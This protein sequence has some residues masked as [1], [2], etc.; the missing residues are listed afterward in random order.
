MNIVVFDNSKG[1]SYRKT[2]RHFS[3]LLVRLTD[4]QFV[5]N[6]PSRIIEQ[7]LKNVRHM[8]SKNSDVL[9]LVADKDGFHG[10]KGYHYGK[11]DSKLKYVNFSNITSLKQFD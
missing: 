9:I 4:R 1:K 8:V 5:G 6:L 11:T 10:W 7:L 3:K 2:R